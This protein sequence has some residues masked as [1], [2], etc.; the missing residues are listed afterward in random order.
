MVSSRGVAYAD[1]VL[2]GFHRDRDGILWTV[3][4]GTRTGSPE[5]AR[6]LHPSRQKVTMQQLLCAGCGGPASRD[7][8][9]MLWVLPLLDDAEDRSW[10]NVRTVIPPMCEVCSTKATQLCPRL[11]DGHVELRVQEAEKIG[12]QGT[13][14]PRP[15]EPGEPDPDALV[16]YD[17]QDQPFVIARQLVRELRQ[18]AVAAVAPPAPQ[19]SQ[20]DH[21]PS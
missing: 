14:Y 4:G 1:P 10:E 5:Y 7:E 3:S 18:V 11:R 8:R 19:E 20:R 9:G 15:G 16:L 2:D 6:E 21:H 13:L 17:S 12:V